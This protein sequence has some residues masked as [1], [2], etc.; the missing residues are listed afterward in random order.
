MENKCN[1]YWKTKEM[2]EGLFEQPAMQIS[3]LQNPSFKYIFEI[4]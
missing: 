2:Y 3:K 4:V 1:V